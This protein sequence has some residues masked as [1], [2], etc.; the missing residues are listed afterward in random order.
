MLLSGPLVSTRD[1][2]SNP[3]GKRATYSSNI[4]IDDPAF[5]RF[6][7][8]SVLLDGLARVAVLEFVPN[9]D[10][11]SPPIP[12]RFSLTML[13]GTPTTASRQSARELLDRAR[14]IKAKGGTGAPP[15]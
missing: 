14:E 13:A 2:R 6:L 5:S 11:V 8:P 12:A 10:R 4:A 9:P 1:T 15:T 7:V 3:L